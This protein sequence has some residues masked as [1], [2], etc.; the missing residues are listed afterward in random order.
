MIDFTVLETPHVIVGAVIATKTANPFLALPLAFSSHF[1]LEKIPHWNPHI[2]KEKE[3]TGKISPKSI[4][5]IIFDASL[6]LFSGLFLS[7]RMLPNLTH[8]LTVFFACFFAVLPDI[9]EIPFYFSKNKKPWLKPIK[10]WVV[11]ERSI[12]K[13][14]SFLPGVL[15]QII[16]ITI[17]L[18]WLFSS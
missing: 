7:F 13:H 5:I 11:F 15:T 16:I 12:Q 3:K 6:A 8:A 14:V 9:I 10:K 1:I 2:F 4:K 18:W 17:S